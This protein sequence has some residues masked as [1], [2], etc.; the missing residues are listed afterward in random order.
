MKNKKIKIVQSISLSL[1]CLLIV[2]LGL[3]NSAP[4][5]ASNLSPQQGAIGIQGEIASPPPTQGATV[6]VPISGTT[7]SSIPIP[8][9]GL[10]ASGTTVKVFS[11][12]VFVGAGTCVNG[13]YSLQINLFSGLNY[14]T[15]VDYD[16]LGQPG[17]TTNVSTVTYNNVQFASFGVQLTLS[18]SYAEEGAAPG[19]EIDWPIIL[20]GGNGPYAISVDWGDGSAAELL[21]SNAAGTLIIKH[22]YSVS[23]VY[24]VI[25]RATDKN[26]DLAFLQLVGQAT[27]AIQQSASKSNNA[28]SGTVVVKQ[29]VL[30]PLIMM[31]PFI[32][33]SFWVGRRYQVNNFRLQQRRFEE[34]EAKQEANIKR[35][36]GKK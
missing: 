17:P 6:V 32:F 7:T 22:T 25:V 13:S 30:W 11:N 26:G 28:A 14:I 3:T 27:G 12:G 15:A 29:L 5:F 35:A 4:A 19:T 24:K 21:S 1:P 20:N 36:S 8:V 9:G 34:A 2:L 31:L 23:G 33:A 18:S 16:A 10:C